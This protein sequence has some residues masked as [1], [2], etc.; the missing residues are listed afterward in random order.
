VRLETAVGRDSEA[1]ATKRIEDFQVEFLP[2]LEA[3]LPR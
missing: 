1:A 2:A 3:A